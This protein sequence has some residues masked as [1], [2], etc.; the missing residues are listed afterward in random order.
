MNPHRIATLTCAVALS[1]STATLAAPPADKGKPDKKA[2]TAAQ[3]SQQDSSDLV[4]TQLSAAAARKIAVDAG[5]SGIKPLPP[6]VRKN[7]ARGKPLPPGIAKSRMPG[8]IISQLPIYRGYEW[9]MAGCDLVL[10][11][12][13]TRVVA[14][15]LRDVFR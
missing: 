3:G 2:A 13:A 12:S 14:D 15:V 6:G 5:L 1:L 11:N 7:L 9:Q 10:V 8:D 4:T